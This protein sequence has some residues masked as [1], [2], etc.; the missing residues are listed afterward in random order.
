MLSIT[1]RLDTDEVTLCNLKLNVDAKSPE[2][3]TMN[4]SRRV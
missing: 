2:I 3:S 4:E 1:S